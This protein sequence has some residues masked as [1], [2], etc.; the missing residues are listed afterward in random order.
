[1]RAQCAQQ[2]LGPLDGTAVGDVHQRLEGCTV[3]RGEGAVS[4]PVGA[5]SLTARMTPSVRG[6]GTPSG[7]LEMG[8]GEG[9]R[10]QL[11][12]LA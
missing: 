11:F 2:P 7:L 3:L 4:G 12:K 5:P 6:Q 9:G 1:M 8:L 10:E